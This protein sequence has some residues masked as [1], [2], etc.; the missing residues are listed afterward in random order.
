MI[1]YE[2]CGAAIKDALIRNNTYF[3]SIDDFGSGNIEEF[4]QLV[5]INELKAEIP[6]IVGKNGYQ[7]TEQLYRQA[8][9]EPNDSE[10]R[11]FYE[12]YIKTLVLSFDSAG[13]ISIKM[14]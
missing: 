4:K 8:R 14:K 5:L 13:N 7:L 6:N 2:K 12:K 10:I 3:C 1:E 11:N 9:L